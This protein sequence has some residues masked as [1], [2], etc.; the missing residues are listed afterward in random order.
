MVARRDQWKKF[1]YAFDAAVAD[2]TAVRPGAEQAAR[3]AGAFA[4]GLLRGVVRLVRAP[5]GQWKI[6]ARR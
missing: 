1:P 3:D 5:G 2:W 6:G 4:E